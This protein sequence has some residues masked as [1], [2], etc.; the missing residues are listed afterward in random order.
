MLK[1]T[2]IWLTMSPRLGDGPSNFTIPGI[3]K[4]K[5]LCVGSIFPES[6]NL[7]DWLPFYS[8]SIGLQN[9]RI[10]AAGIENFLLCAKFCVLEWSI[11]PRLETA[12]HPMR[13]SLYFFSCCMTPLSIPN[14]VSFFGFLISPVSDPFPPIVTFSARQPSTE[15]VLPNSHLLDDWLSILF[16]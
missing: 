15:R 3:Q 1:N 5:Q 11:T 12:L 4:T 14:Q 7:W 13:C 8:R 9:P 6:Y 16:T 2:N 10:P